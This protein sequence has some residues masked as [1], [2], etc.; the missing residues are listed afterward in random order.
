MEKINKTDVENISNK[1]KEV[2]IVEN[3]LSKPIPAIERKLQ[4]N[5]A[6]PWV[7]WFANTNDFVRDL[8][9]KLKCSPASA[10]IISDKV[11]YTIGNELLFSGKDHEKAKTF[12]RSVNADGASLY[13][14]FEKLTR[15]Y[16]SLG[17]AF[18]EVIKIGN[19]INL[20][21]LDASTILVAK[22]E[23]Y[24]N[25]SGGFYYCRDWKNHH[26]FP[27]LYHTRYPEFSKSKNTER[28]IIHLKNYQT[29]YYY[30]G[31][32]D[33]YAAYYSG[34]MNIDYQIAKFNETKFENQFRPS[35][36]LIFTGQALSD[37]EAKNLTAKVQQ[38]WTGE[39]NNSKVI[40]ATVNDP[41]LAPK[42]INFDDAP[43]GAFET[44]QTI[45]NEKIITAHNWHPALILQQSGKLSNANEI[46]TAFELI[47][48]SYIHPNR[49][50][51]TRIFDRIFS[52]QL[53]FSLNPIEV[54]SNSPISYNAQ[55]DPKLLFTIDEQRAM[56]GE[57]PSD[58]A[59]IGNKFLFE[60]N[61]VPSHKNLKDV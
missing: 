53:N 41:S 7:P 2:R 11:I 52:E 26:F 23:N 13:E 54:K 33:Y 35:G 25:P 48:N 50:K 18:L 58:Q 42:W 16:Y 45:A 9:D 59:I 47:C 22:P 32:P 4:Q 37:E 14:V 57:A 51:I 15:D 10:R 12:A 46:Q 8:L 1:I 20:D 27:P 5:N 30:Y 56:L 36:I 28:S 43:S 49:K 38:N 40:I 24:N 34:W 31:L 3:L 61:N 44:L 55:L 39:G 17:N 60:V 29:G 19:R 6:F 21:A